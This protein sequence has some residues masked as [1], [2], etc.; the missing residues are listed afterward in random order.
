ME[1]LTDEQMKLEKPIKNAYTKENNALQ[2]FLRQSGNNN[3][4]TKAVQ[5]RSQ[6]VYYSHRTNKIV[7]VS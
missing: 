7:V 2:K 4:V 3:F 1:Y 5:G 6:N